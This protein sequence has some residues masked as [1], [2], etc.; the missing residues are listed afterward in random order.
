MGVYDE[1]DFF[2]EGL[3]GEI[4]FCCSKIDADGAEFFGECDC[5]LDEQVADAGFAMLGG[6]E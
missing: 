4:I 3:G 6:Y 5:F 2:V 1:A